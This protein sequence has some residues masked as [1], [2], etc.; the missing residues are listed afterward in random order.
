MTSQCVAHWDMETIKSDTL[1]ITNA[2]MHN[3][4][5]EGAAEEG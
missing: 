3:I 2:W 5:N 1:W 4:H